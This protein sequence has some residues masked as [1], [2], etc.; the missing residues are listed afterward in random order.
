M[1]KNAVEHA[2]SEIAQQ[3][4]VPEAGVRRI[5]EER[6]SLLAS[7]ARVK[8]YLILLACKH[9][10]IVLKAKLRTKGSSLSD[11]LNQDNPPSE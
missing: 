4:G 11:I 10:R 1:N 6:L 9:V 3:T 8:D 7:E 5:L 2:V